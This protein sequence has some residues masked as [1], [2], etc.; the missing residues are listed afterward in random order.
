MAERE[1]KAPQAGGQHQRGLGAEWA[2][3]TRKETDASLP[4]REGPGL[5]LHIP[6]PSH[7]LPPPPRTQVPLGAQQTR[8]LNFRPTSTFTQ[9]SALGDSLTSWALPAPS[10]K[11]G[12]RT[13]QRDSSRFKFC[14]S[15]SHFLAFPRKGDVI[16]CCLRSAKC[17]TVVA[18]SDGLIIIEFSV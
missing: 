10:L 6:L 16:L 12:C 18:C 17:P 7:I 14:G 5:S 1:R 15:S 13:D 4:G 3:A 2:W 11:G 8:G 9:Q